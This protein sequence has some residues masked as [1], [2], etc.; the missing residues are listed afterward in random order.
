M[1]NK[2]FDD[3]DKILYKE[4]K[5]NFKITPTVSKRIDDTI[6]MIKQKQKFRYKVIDSLK[7]VAVV[8]VSAVTLFGGYCFAKMII[9]NYF[10]TENN[11]IETAASNG[12]IYNVNS[13]YSISNNNKLKVDNIL[14]DDSTL[15]LS[16]SLELDNIDYNNIE[17][18]I[19]SDILIADDSNNILYANNEESFSDY[20]KKNNLNYNFMDFTEN[21]INSGVNNYIQTIDNNIIKVIYNFTPSAL[22]KYPN[23]KTLTINLKNLRYSENSEEIKGD[24]SFT[25]DLPEY[26]YNRSNISYKVIDSNNSDFKVKEFNVYNSCSKLIMEMPKLEKVVSDEEFDNLI[27]KFLE[28]NNRKNAII[29]ENPDADIP[30]SE[31]EKRLLEIVDEKGAIYKDIYIENS[32]GKKFYPSYTSSENSGSIDIDNDTI[33]YWNTFN[34]NINDL[35]DN[36]TLHMNYNNNEIII[37]LQKN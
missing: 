16:L 29:K 31:T 23:S 1:E 25:I 13:D 28:E 4:F 24:W 33:S 8:S 17:D 18:V 9:E 36:L 35:T 12:Y 30:Q 10:Y 5:Q 3:L 22:S 15:N 20:C 14:M 7:K 19:F 2:D 37:S 27:K 6:N 32:N 34:L 26:F 21:Y 11:G